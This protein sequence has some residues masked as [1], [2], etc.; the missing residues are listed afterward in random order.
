MRNWV[1]NLILFIT[2]LFIAFLFGWLGLIMLTAIYITGFFIKL[3]KH[4]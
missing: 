4:K 1:T 3:F 2:L